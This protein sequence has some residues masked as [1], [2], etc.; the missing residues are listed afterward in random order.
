MQVTSTGSRATDHKRKRCW[1]L[2]VTVLLA[3][4]QTAPRAVSQLRA[5]ESRTNDSCSEAMQSISIAMTLTRDAAFIKPS[6][7]QSRVLCPGLRVWPM[8]QQ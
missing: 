1:A 2:R 6:G 5:M 8:R 4:G 7:W 3:R